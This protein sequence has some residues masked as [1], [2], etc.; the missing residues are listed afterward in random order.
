MRVVVRQGFYCIYITTVYNYVVQVKHTIPRIYVVIP[1][2]TNINSIHD[3]TNLDNSTVLKCIF[4]SIVN[5]GCIVDAWRPDARVCCCCGYMGRVRGQPPSGGD[6]VWVMWRWSWWWTVGRAAAKNSTTRSVC[7]VTFATLVCGHW[8]GL[9]ALHSLF[10][11]RTN[12][13]SLEY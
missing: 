8:K 4:V 6:L 13:I 1:R 2:R 5:D 9:F 12:V 11:A 3:V 10:H 7:V